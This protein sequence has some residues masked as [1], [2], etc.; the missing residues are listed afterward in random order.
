[1]KRKAGSRVARALTIGILR[2]P[3]KGVA[4]QP[5]VAW[6]AELCARKGCSVRRVGLA[7]E[8]CARKGHSERRVASVVEVCARK[9]C[10]VRRVAS[11]AGFGMPCKR[12]SVG[13]KAVLPPQIP[14]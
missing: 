8:L 11:V 12:Y 7:A 6:D 10:S 2:R 9:G 13:I 5:E 14:A 1:M 4:S 3:P